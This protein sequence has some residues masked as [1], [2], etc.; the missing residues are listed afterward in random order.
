[1]NR[2]QL[3]SLS[4]YLSHFITLDVDIDAQGCDHTLRSVEAWIA[5]QN[6]DRE[7][8]LGWLHQR[9]GWCDCRVVELIL[10]A[11]PA[12]LG[13]TVPPQRLDSLDGWMREY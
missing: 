5:H 4:T 6:L 13:E 9:G 8:W 2:T 11:D 1:M 10:L 7:T 12:A 3:F